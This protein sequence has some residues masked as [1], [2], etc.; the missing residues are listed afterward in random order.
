MRA[1]TSA[2]TRKP[3]TRYELRFAG[4]VLAYVNARSEQDAL[5]QLPARYR[6][7]RRKVV[8]WDTLGPA[9]DTN[10]LVVRD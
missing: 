10:G 7:Y 1:R 8:A 2:T 4:M 5:R 6:E 9:R 3:L